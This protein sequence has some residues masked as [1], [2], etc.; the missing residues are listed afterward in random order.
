M[1][2]NNIHSGQSSPGNLHLEQVLSY[3]LRQ[4]PHT[5]SSGMSHRQAA[6][7]F[8]SLMVTFMA[9][10]L[11]SSQALLT[12]RWRSL[13]DC[14]GAGRQTN[15]QGCAGLKWPSP[16]FLNDGI[17]ANVINVHAD[18]PRVSYPQP[19]PPNC[20]NSSYCVSCRARQSILLPLR[21]AA[22][23]PRRRTNNRACTAPQA[24]ASHPHLL[25]D[26]LNLAIAVWL[27]VHADYRSL[28]THSSFQHA[29]HYSPCLLPTPPFPFHPATGGG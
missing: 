20:A 27:F 10:Q 12:L 4:M 3:G 16:L 13:S 8:H 29:S 5:S 15:E 2:P 17:R 19:N 23:S 1:A 26:P 11:S 7:A 25:I 21:G 18:P 28:S 24:R 6:T 22:D 14:V 9:S